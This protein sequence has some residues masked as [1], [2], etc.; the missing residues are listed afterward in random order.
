MNWLPRNMRVGSDAC[1]AKQVGEPLRHQDPD[2]FNGAAQLQD[3]HIQTGLG[4]LCAVSVERNLLLDKRNKGQ[5]FI[6]DF[7]G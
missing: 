5:Y 6:T 3:A 4:P 1:V 7:V 2:L